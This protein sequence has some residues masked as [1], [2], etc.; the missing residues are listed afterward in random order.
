MLGSLED[1]RVT[2]SA[3]GTKKNRMLVGAHR[4]HI[5]AGKLGDVEEPGNNGEH[6]VSLY[7]ASRIPK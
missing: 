5:G 1:S 6:R 3:L 4:S 7:W 2:M